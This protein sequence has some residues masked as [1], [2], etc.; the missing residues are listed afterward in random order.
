MNAIGFGG[1]VELWVYGACVGVVPSPN[2]VVL[3]ARPNTPRR[4]A[5]ESNSSKVSALI[6]WVLR[7]ASAG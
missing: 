5:A 7:P 6:E 1:D 3:S 2:G 4:K